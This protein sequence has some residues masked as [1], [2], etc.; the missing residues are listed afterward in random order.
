LTAGKESFNAVPKDVALV[1]S[2]PKD[3]DLQILEHLRKD[4]RTRQQ[5]AGQ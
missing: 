5:L 4:L 2:H 3:K 1:Q